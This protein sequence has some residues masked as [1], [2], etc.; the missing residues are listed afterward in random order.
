MASQKRD[1]FSYSYPAVEV[2]VE[3]QHPLFAGGGAAPA[4]TRP[5]L[6]FSLC[7]SRAC[8]GKKMIFSI[9]WRKKD[10]VSYM[11]SASSVASVPELVKR[12]RSAQGTSSY[13]KTRLFLS[14]LP[15]FVPSLSWQNDH[16]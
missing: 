11:R 15:M 13:K 3:A 4:E 12:T 8:L 5:F 10:A 7:L 9:R 16:R 6:E 2:S 14:A 1:A